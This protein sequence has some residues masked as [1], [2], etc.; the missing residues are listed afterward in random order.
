MSPKKILLTVDLE[1]WFQVENLRA[2]FP[3]AVWSEC[4]PRIH[5]S[6]NALLELFHNLRCIYLV[7]HRP[8][9]TDTDFFIHARLAMNKVPD[10][11][12]I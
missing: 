5:D 6:V 9:Q 12:N 11:C 3:H 4:E 10:T 8:A 2:H 1:D 7:S